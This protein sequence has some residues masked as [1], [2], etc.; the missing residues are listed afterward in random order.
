MTQ[1]TVKIDSRENKLKDNLKQTIASTYGD[2]VHVQLDNLYCGDFIIEAD[3]Q[4]VAVMERKTLSDLV[5]SIKDGRYRVQ[6]AKLCESFGLACL[7]YVI[8]GTFNY[9]PDSPQSIDGM[10]KYSVMSSIINTQFRDG[11]RVIHTKDLSD[12]HDFIVS[13][14]AR[15]HK[16]PLKYI[17]RDT[18]QNTTCS[19]E[20]LITKHRINTKEDLYFY[21]L[22]QVPGISAKTAQAFVDRYHTMQDFYEVMTPLDDAEKL[23]VLK[24]IMIEDNNKKR[25]ISSKVA[26]N[27][28]KFMF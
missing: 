16:D 12:T 17:P 8:E 7:V 26:E 2:A 10:E 18:K 22:T 27:V 19:K 14:L 9:T 4:P 23:K 5:A 3:G 15:V 28:L 24:N 1:I 20:D 6:K 11:I 21:Q 13:L 25:R